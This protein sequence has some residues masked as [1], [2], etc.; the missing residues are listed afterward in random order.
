[1]TNQPDG[2]E[3][4]STSILITIATLLL[5]LNLSIDSV[6]VFLHGLKLGRNANL[7]QQETVIP[8][9]GKD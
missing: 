9:R 7:P 3:K 8:P 5:T 4:M 1:M 6:Q 2:R